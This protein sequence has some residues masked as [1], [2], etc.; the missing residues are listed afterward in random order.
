MRAFPESMDEY[1]KQLERGY[2]QEAY[3][4]LM[5]YFRDLRAHFKNEYPDYSVP[6]N[7]YHGY[8]DMTY[9][10]IV[11]EFLS[12]RKLKI[13][14]VFVHDQFRFEVW[15]SGTN[16]GVQAEYWKLLK[17]GGW[18]KHDLSSN[19]RAEDYVTGHILDTNP[20]FSDLDALTGQIERG[21]LE[22]IEDVEGFLSE[23]EK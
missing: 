17:E 6:G 10:S 15:L 23:Q 1:R 21:T 3:R 8:M 14:I 13:A 9:F 18:Q 22:F 11:P 5:G 4:G 12:R 16:R 20:D 2:L 7:I 19:P